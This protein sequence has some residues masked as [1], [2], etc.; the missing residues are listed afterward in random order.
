MIESKPNNIEQEITKKQSA[1]YDSQPFWFRIVA[2][3]AL[4]A[5]V[6]AITLSIWL[7]S[8]INATSATIDKTESLQRQMDSLEI[9]IID[10]RSDVRKLEIDALLDDIKGSVD[11][12]NPNLQDIGDGF[13]VGKLSVQ[14]HLTGVKVKGR[15]VNHTALR[16]EN[17]KLKI[18]IGGYTK[19]FTINRISSGNSTS[20]EVYV[21]NVPIEKTQY[22]T[23]R[24]IESMVYYKY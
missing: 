18:T 17:I 2:V 15:M 13:M 3:L 5:S 10:V 19:E 11:F 9:K 6:I 21:P 14:Q 24:Y 7:H 8:R 1:Y 22:G 4:V 20:F 16:Q 12:S 23:I